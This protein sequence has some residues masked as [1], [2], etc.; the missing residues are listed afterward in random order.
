MYIHILN[1]ERPSLR[2]NAMNTT[3]ESNAYKHH[4]FPADF[5]QFRSVNLCTSACA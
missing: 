2:E 5:E 3:S 4:L 1:G